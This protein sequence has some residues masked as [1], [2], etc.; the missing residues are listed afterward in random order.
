MQYVNLEG[1]YFTIFANLKQKNSLPERK[2]ER[3]SFLCRYELIKGTIRCDISPTVTVR[4]HHENL[5]ISSSTAGML[6][7]KKSLSI[8]P[9]FRINQILGFN[10]GY[11]CPPIKRYINLHAD[12]T[13]IQHFEYLGC[14][15]SIE[16]AGLHSFCHFYLLGICRHKR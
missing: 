12:I 13:G 11:D 4:F 1:H 2:R 14:D 8:V 15:G 9:T 7:A 6:V 16:I 5:I 3:K 10:I